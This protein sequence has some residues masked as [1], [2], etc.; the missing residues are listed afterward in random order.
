MFK[1]RHS[2]AQNSQKTHASGEGNKVLNRSEFVGQHPWHRWSRL[3]STGYRPNS[4]QKWPN[5]G[6]V[7]IYPDYWVIVVIRCY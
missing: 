7:R 5:L 4:A 6:I 2:G 3:L 1:A